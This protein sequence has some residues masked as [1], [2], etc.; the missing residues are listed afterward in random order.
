[1]SDVHVQVEAHFRASAR[2]HADGQHDD[3][4]KE[5]QAA[6]KL[7]PESP[8]AHFNMANVLRDKGDLNLAVEGF[9]VALK[10]AEKE[11]RIYPEALQNLGDV[12]NRQGRLDYAVEAFTQSVN[13]APQKPETH[14]GLGMVH[15]GSGN[16]AAAIKH[17]DDA[18]KL[19]PN[20]PPLLNNIGLAQYRLG[21]PERALATY[22]Y[23][24][25]LD[26]AYPEGHTH[27]ALMLLLL[28]QFIEGWREYEWRWQTDFFKKM[29]PLTTAPIWQGE[30]LTGKSIIVYG[31]QG[32]GDTIQFCRYLPLLAAQGAK[33]MAL[34]EASLVPLLNTLENVE[35]VSAMTEPWP[36]HDYVL[37]MMSLPDRFGTDAET[38]PATVPYLSAPPER[39]AYWRDRL[40][41]L[42]GKKVGLVWAGRPEHLFDQERSLDL[43]LLKP[44]GEVPGISLVALQQGPRAG[45][46]G[47]EAMY[48]P[49]KMGDFADTAALMMNLDLIISV[50]TA[51]VH[52]AGALGLP[53]WLLLPQIAEWRWR[54]S[55]ETSA[56]YPTMRLFRRGNEGWEGLV[57]EMAIKL[58]L[59]T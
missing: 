18:I 57:K 3:S 55:G 46:A 22:D 9:I 16:Y 28:G 13:A 27:R 25:K 30:D 2:F 37:P 11:G 52:L 6:L 39:V 58:P 20:N 47:I 36:P 51:P 10:M 7:M 32:Y 1:M 23:I 41:H 59:F 4:V 49:G 14:I 19:Q 44:L 45:E 48:R 50:D 43:E 17:F 40:S 38:I 56:W 8:E 53:T 33:V 15:Y 21:E 26:P 12:F 35:A 5:L 34:V 31:E 42:P 29:Q 24:V 54:V